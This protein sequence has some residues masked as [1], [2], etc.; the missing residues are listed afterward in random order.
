MAYLNVFSSDRPLI[1]MSHLYL[2]V[3]CIS[4]CEL[5][6]GHRVSDLKLTDRLNLGFHDFPLQI[7]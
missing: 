5:S 4:E 3:G 2:Q 6:S 1:N 7:K